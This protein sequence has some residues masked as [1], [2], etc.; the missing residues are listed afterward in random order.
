MTEL[1]FPSDS[2]LGRP[3]FL[4]GCATAS[5]QIEGAVH[6]G[7]RE[8]SIWDI[9]CRKPGAILD[10]S[11]GDVACDHIR[12]MDSDLDLIRELGFRAYRFSI[13]WPRMVTASGKPNPAGVDI[14]NRLVD[15]MLARDIEPMATLYHWDL[16][17]RLE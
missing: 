10:D 12:L 9:F 4:I 2:P 14:Y 16:P 3:D 11:N 5:Y 15:G 7:G 6:D 13:A 17:Q 8:A 1:R